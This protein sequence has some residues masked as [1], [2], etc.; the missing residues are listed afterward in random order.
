MI[1]F[2][3]IDGAGKS[4]QIEL[5]KTHF[6]QSE[7]KVE[8]FWS[9]GGYSP[10]MML[11]KSLFIKK[12]EIEECDESAIIIR[13][14][15]FSKPLIRKTWLFLSILDL[16]YFY[17]IYIRFKELLGIKVI[18]DR[19]IFDTSI[20]FRLNFPQEKV[21]KWYLWRF[22]IFFAIR[23]KRHFVIT[24]PVAE[25]IR[26]SALKDEPFPD[27]LETLEL[28]LKDYLAFIAEKKFT[29]HIDGTKEI[30]DIHAIIKVDIL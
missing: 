27:T 13:D 15:Q 5:L 3:G 8:L 1:A 14:K 29:V 12:K 4:T 23:P 7:K 18:C 16:I 30:D 25:S 24:I 10:G 28:R 20:D 22:L 26:R 19:Y 2:S 6:E 11:L 17:G 9:R 21:E